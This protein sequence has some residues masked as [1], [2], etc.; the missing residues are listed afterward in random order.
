[1]FRLEHPGSCVQQVVVQQN[2][3]SLPYKKVDLRSYLEQTPG[4]WSGRSIR[5]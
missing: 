5:V 3:P 1:M 4:A 2:D